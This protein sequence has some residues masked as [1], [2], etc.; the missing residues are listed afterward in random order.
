MKAFGYVCPSC[1]PIDFHEAHD[2]IQCRCGLTA[3]RRYHVAINKSSLK[4]Q[5][6][7]D[8]VVGQ[9]VKNDAEF[10]SVLAKGQDEQAKK[11]GMDVHL[12]M[13]DSRDTEALAE[14]HGHSTEEREA[15]KEGTQ[16]AAFDKANA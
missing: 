4:V 7:W 15:V 11:L 5:E 10:R 1:G 2:S 8:P 3:R 9:Y 13:V 16:K 6:R 14:L 12:K